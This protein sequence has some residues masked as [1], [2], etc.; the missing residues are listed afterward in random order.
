MHAQMRDQMD[1]QMSAQMYDQMRAQMSAQMDAQMH[2]QMDAQMSE[3]YKRY[4]SYLYTMDVYSNVLIAWFK[5]A[6]LEVG[7][8]YSCKEML[9]EWDELYINS[10]I[11][12]CQL[13]NGF[14]VVSKYPKKV[15]RNENNDLNS[16]DG[17]AVEWGSNCGVYFDCYYVNG[18]RLKS[19]LFKKL[20][21]NEYTV[22]DFFKEENE[23]V[24]SAV[25]S[26]IQQSKG[27]DG[28][29]HFFKKNLKE[30]DHFK[31]E[32]MYLEGTTKGENIGF[33]TLLKGEI[34]DVQ[35]AYVRCYCPSTDRMFFLGVE[36]N[37]TN[38]KDAIASLFE[39][40][41]ILKNNIKSISRQ[42]EKF[43]VIFDDETTE[44]L[45][46]N[47]FSKEQLSEFTTI[48]GDEYFSKMVYEY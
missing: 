19:E 45:E 10:G 9:M 48:S 47:I 44:K 12:S 31:N 29:Y 43:S 33:Y 42:G 4:T 7:V 25:V 38:A 16:I 22:E 11:Y 28:I 23:E 36:P 27:D 39:V 40:P 26:F 6:C 37:Q 24:K 5:F 3:L 34:N 14:C 17:V 20:K 32:N 13:Y 46:K 2:D 35:I 18:F 30:V 8:N 41:R 21:S 1:A 15:N